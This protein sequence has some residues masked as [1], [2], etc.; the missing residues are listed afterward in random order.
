MIWGVVNYY[1]GSM[2]LAN[3]VVMVSPDKFGF[4]PQTAGTNP[5]QHNIALP[6]QKLRDRAMNEFRNMVA[7]LEKEKIR[8]LILGSRIDVVT[9]DAVFPNNW[10]SHHR[11]GKLVVYP[12]FAENRR[13]E[14]QPHN[15]KNL[16]NDAGIDHIKMIDMTKDELVNQFLEGTGSMVLDRK[17]RVAF[18]MESER[19]HRQEFNKWCRKMGYDGFFLHA[20]DSDLK[21]IY[22]TNIVMSLGDR[23]AVVCLNAIN[24]EKERYLLEKK[25]RQI[26]KE[27]IPI[28]VEQM[29]RFCG[30][31]I[32]LNSTDKKPKIIMSETAYGA[33]TPSQ[34]AT[35]K[36]YGK[37]VTVPIPTIETVGGGSA[38]CMIAEI[39]A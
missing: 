34:K 17:N 31:I 24:S 10:F 8:T 4:N 5:F 16:L 3:T 26:K 35:L 19:T 27:I 12:M 6:P 25:L 33:F 9:P 37:L 36:K 13:M 23:Y 22:H 14:R 1:N 20:L 29:D 7:I 2:S 39:F 15:L 30:N 38:R 32:Q 21:P 18:A 11:D 28:T